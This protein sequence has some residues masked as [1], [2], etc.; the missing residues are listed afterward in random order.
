MSWED[1]FWAKVSKNDGDGCW[2]WTGALFRTKINDNNAHGAFGKRAST[3][4]P[5][6]ATGESTAHRISWFLAYGRIP[7]GVLILHRCDN[8]RCVRPSHLFSGDVEDNAS[9]RKSKGRYVFLLIPSRPEMPG[10]FQHE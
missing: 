6:V 3:S 2:T 8:R 5:Y 9:D 10:Y 7:G 4:K 1:N